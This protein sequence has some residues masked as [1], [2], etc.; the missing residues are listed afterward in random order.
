MMLASN[1]SRKHDET[2]VRAALHAL[3]R[4][5]GVLIAW[6]LLIVGICFSILLLT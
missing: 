1:P 5:A 3:I 4:R 2:V 6:L